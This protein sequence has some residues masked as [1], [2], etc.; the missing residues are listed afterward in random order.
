V[1]EH[2]GHVQSTSFLERSVSV[3]VWVM[4][5]IAIWHACVLVPDRFYGGIVGAFIVAVSGALAA[6]YL[7]PTPGVPPHN[8]PGLAEA[9]WPIPGSLVALVALYRYGVYREQLD[10]EMGR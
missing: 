10:E 1:A 8:P 7:L 2:Q 4:I 5:G 9:L 3:F 6:G